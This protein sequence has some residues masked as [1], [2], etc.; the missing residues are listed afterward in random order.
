[1]EH[2]IEI[3]ANCPANPRDPNLLQDRRCRWACCQD[4][5]NRFLPYQPASFSIRFVIP[6]A[7]VMRPRVM[8]TGQPEP[9]AVVV[10]FWLFRKYLWTMIETSSFEIFDEF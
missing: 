6:D 7:G 2:A 4:A 3:E 10:P 9:V 8:A 5:V 1:M